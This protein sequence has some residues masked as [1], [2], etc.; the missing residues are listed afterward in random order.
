MYEEIKENQILE[1]KYFCQNWEF[2]FNQLLSC[3]KANFEKA[4]LLSQY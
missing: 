1:T 4:A 2:I 3:I